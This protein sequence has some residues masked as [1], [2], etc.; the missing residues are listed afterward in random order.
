MTTPAGREVLDEPVARVCGR[1]IAAIFPAYTVDGRG[2]EVM[3]LDGRRVVVDGE[4]LRR[5]EVWLAVDD[6]TGRRCAKR[7]SSL[8]TRCDRSAGHAG[9]CSGRMA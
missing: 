9:P 3:L 8:E 5:I 7:Y 2:V 4:A 6:A 1:D